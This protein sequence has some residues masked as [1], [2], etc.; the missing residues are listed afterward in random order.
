MLQEEFKK[1]EELALHIKAYIQTEIELIKLLLAEK[2]SKILSN[3]LAIMVLI[4]LLLIGI[5]FASLSLA[6]LIGEKLGKMSTGFIIVS[7]IYLLLAVIT[8]YLREKVIRIPIL[9]GI[10]RQLFDNENKSEENK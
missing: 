2:L 7:F 5:L 1:V 9:N 10:L 4:W 3:F 6:F 8:W